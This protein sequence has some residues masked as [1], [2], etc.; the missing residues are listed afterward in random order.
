M[1]I[2]SVSWVIANWAPLEHIPTPNLI[3][4]KPSPSN[5]PDNKLI[6]AG[7][8]S[9][10]ALFTFHNN[11]FSSPT[12]C[13]K[14]STT[15]ISSAWPGSFTVHMTWPPHPTHLSTWQNA[16]FLLA[17]NNTLWTTQSHSHSLRLADIV[18][19]PHS[20]IIVRPRILTNVEVVVVVVS[21]W[22]KRV[23]LSHIDSFK[24]IYTRERGRITSPFIH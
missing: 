23:S 4:S 8:I 6:K 22:S 15:D 19:P 13:K 10:P 11:N 2:S 9:Y 16:F 24:C 21:R 20:C 7:S 1:A 12:L 14:N 3:T 18:Q 5:D 17:K